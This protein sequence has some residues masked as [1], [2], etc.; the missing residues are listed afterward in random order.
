[1]YRDASI[2]ASTRAPWL[3]SLPFIFSL[4]LSA[5]RSFLC[6][7]NRFLA[8]TSV[9]MYSKIPRGWDEGGNCLSSW[10]MKAISNGALWIIIVEFFMN[11]RNLLATSLNLGF[12]YRN[13]AVMLWM[14]SALGS[15]GMSGCRYSWNTF[16]VILP[17]II[18]TQPI[19]IIRC[20]SQMLRPLRFLF[21]PVVSVSS[22]I[23]RSIFIGFWSGSQFHLFDPERKF[24]SY[25]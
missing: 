6:L 12:E 13:S 15:I 14:A 24:L 23:I 21:I 4:S 18:S 9:S 8:I 10:S 11:W 16:P 20:P 2:S 22:A 1:M 7:G 3:P 25:G 17:F 19:S 5:F